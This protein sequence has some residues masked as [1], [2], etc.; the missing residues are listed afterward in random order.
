MPYKVLFLICPAIF[1]FLSAC[2]IILIEEIPEPAEYTVTFIT[3]RG[4]NWNK[5]QIIVDDGTILKSEN[6]PTLQ[7]RE[8][9]FTFVGWYD[10]DG[11]LAVPDSYAVTKDITLK[12]RWT[13]G[14]R[15]V[16]TF[17]DDDGVTELRAPLAKAKNEPFTESDLA[18]PSPK[19][20][21]AFVGWYY[22]SG[23]QAQK[24]QVIS[25]NST[26]TA[27]WTE[28]FYVITYNQGEHGT[29]AAPDEKSVPYGF[30]LT[31][32]ELPPRTDARQT[33]L[34]WYYEDGS[35]AVAGNQVKEN[36]TLIARW[37]AKWCITYQTDHG[38]AASPVYVD[39]GTALTDGLLAV[40]SGVSETEWRFDEWRYENAARAQTGDLITK[41]TVLIALWVQ[42]VTITYVSKHGTPPAAKIEDVNYQLS[43]EDVSRDNSKPKGL[44]GDYL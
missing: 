43:A 23:D 32:S 31:N 40:P 34:G 19:Q 30:V 27:R 6:L 38:T 4:G 16:V 25:E 3:E 33:F 12:A 29:E 35:K 39:D 13:E 5:N 15:F 7:D 28:I 1:C 10:D 21:Y 42:R 37:Q 36:I 22:E 26:L 8:A 18:A 9:R 14:P 44:S 41:D 24:D 11:V 17:F 20:G 2:R